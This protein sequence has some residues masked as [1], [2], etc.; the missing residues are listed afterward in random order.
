MNDNSVSSKVMGVVYID[1]VVYILPG[2]LLLGGVFL[3]FG[4]P[5]FLFSWLKTAHTMSAVVLL[6]LTAGVSYMIGSVLSLLLWSL[7]TILESKLD[8]TSMS[9]LLQKEDSQRFPRRFYQKPRLPGAVRLKL[10]SRIEKDLAELGLVKEVDPANEKV[11]SQDLVNFFWHI[12]R[13]ISRES[14]SRLFQ[15]WYRWDAVDHGRQNIIGATLLVL[16]MLSGK[17]LVCSQ[18]WL[19]FALTVF[20]MLLLICLY[21]LFLPLARYWNMSCFL[22]SYLTG[23]TKVFEDKKGESSKQKEM[24]K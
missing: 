21:L 16:V 18:N 22:V 5:N 17:I 7:N 9:A 12:L 1:L 23:R 6:I 15:Y 2:F 11:P 8:W 10:R 14:N 20:G 4:N 13:E 19:A 3:I 24:E